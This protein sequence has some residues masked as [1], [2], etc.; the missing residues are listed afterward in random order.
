M[1]TPEHMTEE[2]RERRQDR[3]GDGGKYSFR[4]SIIFNS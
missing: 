4:S 2:E 1:H 3:G